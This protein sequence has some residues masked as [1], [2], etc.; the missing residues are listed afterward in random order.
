MI[1]ACRA[2]FLF[3]TFTVGLET[4][5]LAAKHTWCSQMA[6]VSIGTMAYKQ[7]MMNLIVRKV[8][9][10]YLLFALIIVKPIVPEDF[11]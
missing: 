8:S 2:Q 11:K 6:L 1:K 4:K 5:L 3:D 7:I 9:V 10:I